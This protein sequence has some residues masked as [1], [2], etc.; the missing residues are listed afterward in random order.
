MSEY[1]IEDQNEFETDFV[2]DMKA[3]LIRHNI[4]IRKWKEENTG[5]FYFCSDDDKNIFMTVTDIVDQLGFE[6]I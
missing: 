2:A 3:F 5:D 6:V 1:K 4:I